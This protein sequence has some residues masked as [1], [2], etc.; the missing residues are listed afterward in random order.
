MLLSDSSFVFLNVC[1]DAFF[2]AQEKLGPV[3]M[4][5][6][7]AGMSVSGKFEDLEVSTFEVSKNLF[8]D[9][10]DSPYTKS[11]ASLYK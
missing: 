4:L 5:I 8:F 11:R 10:G 7:C 6:N 9:H 3:D 2:Q 1:S